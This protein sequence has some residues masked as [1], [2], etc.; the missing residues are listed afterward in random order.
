MGLRYRYVD[1]RGHRSN[2]LSEEDL[3][4][5]ALRGILTLDGMVELEAEDA[6]GSEPGAGPVLASPR[7][8]GKVRE[9]GWLA[10]LL[11]P[12]PAP[13]PPALPPSPAAPPLTSLAT[14]SDWT[15]T[16]YVLLALLPAFLGVFGIGNVLIG[17]VAVGIVQLVL[18][19]FTI[20]GCAFGSLAFPCACVGVPLYV[21]LLVWTVVE[22]VVVETDARGRRLR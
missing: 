2:A 19:I 6:F 16:N 11:V 10:A 15:R 21:A 9:I 1:E 4:L 3:R 8:L 14:T 7:I 12:P 18:S 5:L 22:V 13:L 17:R 20:S